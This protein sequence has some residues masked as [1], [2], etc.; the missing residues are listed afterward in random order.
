MKT[1]NAKSL[2]AIMEEFLGG[3]RRALISLFE[4]LRRPVYSYLLRLSG[5]SA[6]A[7]D[8]LQETFIAVHTRGST[9][10][11]GRK[12][13]PWI[14]T[15]ARN[16]FYEWHRREG[17]V[18]RL[19]SRADR[20]LELIHPDPSAGL[21]ERGAIEAALATL[22]EI[23]RETFFLKH[24]AGMTFQE[25]ADLHGVPLPTVKSRMLFSL[26]KLREILENDL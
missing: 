11:S 6:L 12:V 2:E 16:K 1:E 20:H 15:I 8:L 17:K 9:F 23:N 22:S 4:A 5:N 10:H 14:M 3:D 18:V 26:K 25:I 13:L 7:E 19:L 21:G 24:V